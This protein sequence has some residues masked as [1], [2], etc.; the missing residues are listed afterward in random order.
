MSTTVRSVTANE[1]PAIAVSLAKAFHD[2]PVFAALF[3]GPVPQRRATRFFEIMAA[4]Q[5]RHQHVYRTE[6][7]EAAAIWTPPDAWKT[8]V[9]AIVRNAPGLMWVLGRRV[10][11][12]RSIL[13]TLERHHPAEPHYYLEFLGT[14]PEHQGRGLGGQLLTPMMQRCDDEGV[15][16]YLESS[17]E[18]NLAFYRR[19]GF[20][21]TE[22]ITHRAG[23][24]QWLMWREPH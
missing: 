21:V 17:K 11:A 3:G 2:D 15:G 23:V 7:S 19:Y 6:G 20:E 8:P 5:L 13:T 1:V 4:L 14:A 12:S 24:Q 10:F 18:S 9:A 16:A 22:V